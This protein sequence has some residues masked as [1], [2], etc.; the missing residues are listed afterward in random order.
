M[1][2]TVCAAVEG[3]DDLERLLDVP[4]GPAGPAL[5]PARDALLETLRETTLDRL[6]PPGA[7]R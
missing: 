5:L 6:V 3:A 7:P 2:A 1:G 4:A